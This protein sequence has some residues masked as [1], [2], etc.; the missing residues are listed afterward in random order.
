[1]WICWLDLSAWQLRRN[2]KYRDCT[3]I[4]TTE[5]L[6]ATESLRHL[7]IHLSIHWVVRWELVANEREEPVEELVG[8]LLLSLAILFVE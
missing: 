8:V 3:K 1:M 7:E 4:Y 2:R 5:L 6:G